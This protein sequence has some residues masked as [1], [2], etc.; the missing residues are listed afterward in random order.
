MPW[1]PTASDRGDERRGGLMNRLGVPGSPLSCHSPVHL[2]W[3]D[4]RLD[5]YTELTDLKTSKTAWRPS[6]CSNATELPSNEA[7]CGANT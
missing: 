1:G 2:H 5:R 7:Q 4:G 3:N 6:G